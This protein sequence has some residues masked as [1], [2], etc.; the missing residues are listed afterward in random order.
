MEREPI[1]L[2]RTSRRKDYQDEP[3]VH[4]IMTWQWNYYDKA[5]EYVKRMSESSAS[6]VIFPIYDVSAPSTFN[7][8]K[9]VDQYTVPNDRDAP[10]YEANW[11]GTTCFV[12]HEGNGEIYKEYCQLALVLGKAFEPELDTLTGSVTLF[13]TVGDNPSR[14]STNLV[15][16]EIAPAGSTLPPV[17]LTPLVV[18]SPTGTTTT[19]AQLSPGTYTIRAREEKYPFCSALLSVIIPARDA[20]S[21]MASATPPRKD[22]TQTGIIIISVTNGYLPTEVQY[23]SRSSNTWITKPLTN[24]RAAIEYLEEGLYDIKVKDGSVTGPTVT[25]EVRVPAPL[26]SSCILNL[27]EVTALAPLLG[28]TTGGIRVRVS[29]VTSTNSLRH[30]VDVTLLLLPDAVNRN[31]TAIRYSYELGPTEFE[32]TFT[33]LVPGT[34]RVTALDTYP[35]PPGYSACQVLHEPDVTVPMPPPS[36]YSFLPWV[37]QRLARLADITPEVMRPSVR[38]AVQTRVTTGSSTGSTEVVESV[39]QLEL[40]G[41]GDIVGLD[42]RAVLKTTPVAD[43]Q[44]FSPLHLASIEFKEEDLPWR[45]SPSAISN[46]NTQATPWL[47]LLTLEEAEYELQEQRNRP[48]PVVRIQAGP[49]FPAKTSTWPWAHVQVNKQL[50][51]GQYDSPITPDALVSEM[52]LNNALA[53]DPSLAFSRVFSA[54]RLK[55][56]TRYQSFLLPSFETGRLTGLGLPIPTPSSADAF[57]ADRLAWEGAPVGS[58]LDFPVYYQWSFQTGI[59]EDFESLARLLTPLSALE[60][61][62]DEMIVQLPLG[63]RNVAQPTTRYT[64]TMPSILESLS[65]SSTAP[66]PPAIATS[67]YEELR[68]GFDSELRTGAGRPIVTAPFY[69]R[70][71]ATSGTLT[72]PDNGLIPAGWKHEVN[73][74]PRYR[75][76]ANLGSQV[77]QENQE[78]YMQRAWSQVQDLV[79]VNHNLRS[80]QFGLRTNLSLR[81]K[82]LPFASGNT[83]FRVA[84]PSGGV[85]AGSAAEVS[86]P[87]ATNT[88]TAS[89]E[90]K[91][92]ISTVNGME[93]YGLQLSAISM[94]R[95]RMAGSGLTAWETVRRSD[96]PLAVFSPAF[97]RITQP[98]GRYQVGQAGRPLRP[99]QQA[100]DMMLENLQEKGTSLQQRDQLF[101]LLQSGALK[102]A[103]CKPDYVRAYQF[104]DAIVDV[105]L[106]NSAPVAALHIIQENEEPQVI[107]QNTALAAFQAAYTEF[108][109]PV[110][111]LTAEQPKP[112]LRLDAI[113]GQ[114]LAASHP[115]QVFTARINHT[116]KQTTNLPTGDWAASDFSGA[117]FLLDEEELFASPPIGSNDTVSD[118]AGQ[119]RA[120]NA[121]NLAP[122]TQPLQAQQFPQVKPVMAHPIF[123]D[124]MGDVLRKK[125]P[126]LFLPGIENFPANGVTLLQ[127]NR[128]FIEAYLLGLNHAFGSEL[129]WR[130]YPTDLRGSYFQQFWDVSEFINLLP[131]G[132]LS[133]RELEENHLDV[134]PLHEWED[135][136]LQGNRQPAAPEPGMLLAIRADLLRRFPNTVICLQAAKQV[137]V[138]TTQ[139]WVP[140]PMETYYPI[141]RLLLG[142]DIMALSFTL[143]PQ[144]AMGTATASDTAP[145]GYFIVFMERP[146]EPQFGLDATGGVSATDTDPKSWN[147]LS[148]SYMGTL[149]G[150]NLVVDPEQ[151]PRV[152]T[153]VIKR[154]ETSAHLAYALLQEPAIVAIHAQDLLQVP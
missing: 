47:T 121:P 80:L 39:L 69:G 142:Q 101:S 99:S 66:I 6:N 41:P 35:P 105:I 31:P 4:T 94:A 133:P 125:H 61:V 67:L 63:S 45:Y 42:P 91:E 22:T 2:Y 10:G 68:P 57:P 144:Q 146:G 128:K 151:K 126:E 56:N 141:G 15:L 92:E 140:D 137:V 130:E 114:V 33:N 135:T 65:S 29:D 81:A 25:T 136:P 73:L 58:D 145:G 103:A 129:L 75:A 23:K 52:F 70:Y 143:T 3:S 109:E 84:R 104:E 16:L 8:D 119:N 111:F 98:F 82:H 72:E 44:R 96:V 74:D 30:K 88:T 14:G 148:W 131:A 113:K 110:Q 60:P 154:I 36:H 49:L 34:Y 46:S 54:R 32:H 64:L 5:V 118:G 51:S 90:E 20:M 85:V 76:I 77:I 112:A 83:S 37:K 95:T 124:A 9:I 108:K 100:P 19:I 18:P 43:E 53:L 149:P 55:P 78:E 62:Q 97:R 115:A 134:R 138:G 86:T 48:L 102:G 59:A 87:E 24:R 116:I 26:V 40:N 122:S 117:D 152:L 50:V 27:A 1:I 153:G 21:V 38:M 89:A 123:R 127:I 71:Y 147:D 150:E 132:N 11:V 13:V 7:I 93:N 139:Q 12:F 28:E 120:G 17:A 107:T 106:G 79:A